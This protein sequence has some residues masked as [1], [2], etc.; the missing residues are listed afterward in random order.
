MFCEAEERVY[1]LA[2]KIY[3]FLLALFHVLFGVLDIVGGVVGLVV[4]NSL[5]NG[6][7]LHRKSRSTPV[8][9]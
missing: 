7:S 8:G 4:A 5:Q 2:Q 9:F 6:C 1:L 3:S